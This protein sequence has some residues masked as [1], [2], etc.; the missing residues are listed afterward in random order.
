V[1]AVAIDEHGEPVR[2]VV[3]DPRTFALHKVWLSVRPD[4]EPLKV[5]RDLEQAKAAATIATQYLRLPFDS[6]ELQ[7]LPKA[8]RDLSPQLAAAARR[9]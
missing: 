7:A 2:L 9:S 3:I 6:P 5:K 1:E 8:L 4:R